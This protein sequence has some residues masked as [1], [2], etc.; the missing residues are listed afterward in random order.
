MTTGQAPASRP[1]TAAQL[2]ENGTGNTE[3]SA[4]PPQKQELMQALR[5]AN[6]NIT[7]AAKLLEIHRGTV[8][9]RMLKWGIDLRRTVFS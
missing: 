6:G 5:Q 3:T 1:W 9:N 4:L 8:R 2:R 7:E